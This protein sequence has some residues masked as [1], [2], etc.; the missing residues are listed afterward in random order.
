MNMGALT[1]GCGVVFGTRFR[2]VG[3]GSGTVVSYGVAGR[4]G[5]PEEP[6]RAAVPEVAWRE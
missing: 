1:A 4:D 2:V 5:A 6:R 3:W